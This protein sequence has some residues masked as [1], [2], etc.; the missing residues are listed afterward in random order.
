MR[1][2]LAFI[3]YFVGKK[4]KPYVFGFTDEQFG[5]VDMFSPFHT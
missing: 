4:K 3:I 5:R 1:G 2:G